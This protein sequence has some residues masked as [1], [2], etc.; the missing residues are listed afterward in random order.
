MFFLLTPDCTQVVW[1]VGSM[2]SQIVGAIDSANSAAGTANQTLAEIQ[3]VT[4]LF[5]RV[6]LSEDAATG[7]A[8]S[9]ILAGLL[10]C[11]LGQRFAR[12]FVALVAFVV[13]T[14]IFMYP[15]DAAVGRRLCPSGN[16][17]EICPWSFVIGMFGGLVVAAAAIR[18][19][20]F[21]T[22]ALGVVMGLLG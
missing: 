20:K 18:A 3:S 6:T 21:A 12:P 19:Q 15:V 5:P 22:I 17:D 8:S 14:A 11:A 1:T 2:A 7:I 13:G 9:M 10:A 4:M 16:Q